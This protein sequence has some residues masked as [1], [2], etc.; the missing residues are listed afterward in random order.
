M[1]LCPMCDTPLKTKFDT[2]G[3]P[4]YEYCPECKYMN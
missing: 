4:E 2:Q 1:K 3:I